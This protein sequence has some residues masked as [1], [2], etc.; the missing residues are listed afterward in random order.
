L[1]RSPVGCPK[2]ELKD[3][4]KKGD[5]A[6]RGQKKKIGSKGFREVWLNKMSQE[7]AF[8]ILSEKGNLKTTNGRSE[9]ISL[10]ERKKGLGKRT[11]RTRKNTA[12][13]RLSWPDGTLH[14]SLKPGRE[15]LENSGNT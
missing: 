9:T 6:Q 7:G 12:E 13:R 15:N 2:K 14:A 10:G 1:K 11:K 8:G 4:K 5:L 3:Q